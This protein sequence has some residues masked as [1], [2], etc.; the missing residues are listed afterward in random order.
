MRR[1]S[2]LAAIA[3]VIP[4]FATAAACPDLQR[5]LSF[6][7]SGSDVA[8]LQQYLIENGHLEAGNATGFFGMLTQSGLQKFQ[9]EKGIICSG[10]PATTGWGVAG[11][12]TRAAIRDACAASGGVPAPVAPLPP[13]AP[14][15]PLVIRPACGLTI[16]PAFIAPGEST[17]LSWTSSDASSGALTTVGIVPPSGSKAITPYQSGMYLFVALGETDAA[18]CTASVTVAPAPPIQP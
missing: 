12:Q 13:A 15:Q 8:A 9:C 11:P 10:E 17:T 3:C 6:G 16:T 5:T 2:I 7:D 18:W 4:L 14:Y 1:T